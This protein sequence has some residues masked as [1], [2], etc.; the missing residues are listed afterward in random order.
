MY[1]DTLNAV[2]DDTRAVHGARAAW[3]ARRVGETKVRCTVNRKDSVDDLD[4]EDAGDLFDGL[5]HAARVA[6]YRALRD[7]GGEMALKDLRKAVSAAWIE[8][9]RRNLEFHLA[10]M[11][12]AGLVQV[13][14]GDEGAARLVKWV[15]VRLSQVKSN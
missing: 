9:D 11:R 4:V 10:K 8:I 3:A 5:A 1:E 14:L 2:Y 12:M 13:E 6:I 7:A 15:D